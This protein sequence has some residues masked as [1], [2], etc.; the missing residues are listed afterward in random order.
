V[1]PAPWWINSEVGDLR[2]DGLPVQ[3]DAGWLAEHLDVK[4]PDRDVVRVRRMD[5]TGTIP[6]AYEIGRRA[7][8][9]QVKP[10]HLL[11][12]APVS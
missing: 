3:H 10:E 5:H 4:L 6:L 12:A 9:R 1:C 7:A 11:N 8:Q 2:D